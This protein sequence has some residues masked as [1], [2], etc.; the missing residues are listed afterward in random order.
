MEVMKAK[1]E[2]ALLKGEDLKKILHFLSTV[3]KLKDFPD[4]P[5]SSGELSLA[6][7]SCRSFGIDG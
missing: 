4:L 5:N 6:F 3:D 7:H 2:I 1:A